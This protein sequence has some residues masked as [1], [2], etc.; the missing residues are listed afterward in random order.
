MIDE[1]SGL[2]AE[3]PAMSDAAYADGLRRLDA[4]LAG[5]PNRTLRRLRPSRRTGYAVIAA[6]AAAAALVTGVTAVGR[7]KPSDTAS[8]TVLTSAAVH[9]LSQPTLHPRPGQFVYVRVASFNNS[10]HGTL[11]YWIPA[12]AGGREQICVDGDDCTTLS[13]DQNRLKDQAQPWD[14]LTALPTD[15]AGMLAWLRSNPSTAFHRSAGDAADLAVWNT[16]FGIADQFPPAQQS[17]LFRALADLHSVRLEGD[18]TTFDGQAGVALGI[19]D[20]AAGDR[21]LVFARDTFAYI[22]ERN[23]QSGTSFNT[24]RTTALVVD[25]TGQRP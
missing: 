7:S 12:N 17:A 22:G 15:E 18:V 21:Q 4:A 25:R 11:E 5:E 19:H 23:I 16:A 6:A 10:T 8:A 24:S 3:V 1:L 2:R 14:V 20:P 13:Y 9:A